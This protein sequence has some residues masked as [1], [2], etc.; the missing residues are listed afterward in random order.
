MAAGHTQ[1]IPSLSLSS[2]PLRVRHTTVKGTTY[3]YTAGICVGLIG[4]GDPSVTAHRAIEQALPLTAATVGIGVE[5]KWLATDST[6]PAQLPNFDGLWCVPASPYRDT[7]A[8]LAA[9]NYGREHPF[10][11]T[12]GGFQHALLEYARNALSWRDAGRAA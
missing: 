10:L 7:D 8:V 3:D 5:F 9:I 1:Q 11:G 12:Y 6:A 2:P 4:D